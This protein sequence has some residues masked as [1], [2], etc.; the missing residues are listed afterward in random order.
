M[1]MEIEQRFSILMHSVRN[2]QPLNILMIIHSALQENGHVIFDA[3]T[4]DVS[5]QPL[6]IFGEKTF[7][8]I[9]E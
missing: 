8:V 9:K 5:S 7:G 3:N 1:L 4:F 2:S 6:K